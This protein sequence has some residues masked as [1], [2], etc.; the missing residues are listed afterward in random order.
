MLKKLKLKNWMQFIS[1][2]FNPLTH[3][4]MIFL[5]VLTHFQIIQFYSVVREINYFDF[6]LAFFYVTFFFFKLRL[7]DEIKDYDSD[8]LLR[9]QRPLP[10]GLLEVDDLKLAIGILIGLQFVLASLLNFSSLAFVG[11]TVAYSLL[12]YNEF[13]IPKWLGPKL[14]TYAVTHTFV[15]ILLSVSLFDLISDSHFSTAMP[16]GFSLPLTLY[17]ISTWF[18]FNVFEFARKTY[19]KDEERS[20]V[21]SYS[22]VWGRYGAV[23][24]TLSQAIIASYFAHYLLSPSPFMTYGLALLC[25]A[26]G[27][28]GLVYASLNRPGIAKLY[29]GLSSGF[30][31]FY[32]LIINLRFFWG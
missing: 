32:F 10:R 14:T 31:I 26:V 17:A 20:D 16:L 28:L 6:V 19:S 15:T 24:L 2:R 13:F 1:E 5:F 12:M 7:Y 3:L 8:L 30:I 11:V 21:L 29:R 23:V 22:K 9:P 25:F 18:L 4:S 27:I